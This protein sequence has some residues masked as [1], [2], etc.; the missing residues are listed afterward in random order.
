M[1]KLNEKIAEKRS[2]SLGNTRHTFEPNIA[3]AL[4]RTTLLCIRGTRDGKKKALPINELAFAVAKE[5]A[6]SK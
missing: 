1:K 2:E 6:V 4:L 5:E 3:S